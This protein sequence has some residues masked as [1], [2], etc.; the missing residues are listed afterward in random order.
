M[1]ERASLSRKPD[2]RLSNRMRWRLW[3]LAQFKYGVGVFTWRDLRTM[4][5]LKRRGL[6]RFVR[7]SG[8]DQVY[9]LTGDGYR[10]IRDRWPVSPAVLGSYA[11]QPGGWDLLDDDRTLAVGTGGQTK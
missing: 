1:T 7:L 11:E 6:V 10:E 2:A 9:E 8:L 5:A 4:E 3:T